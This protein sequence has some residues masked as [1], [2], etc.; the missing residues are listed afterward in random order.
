ML[1]LRSIVLDVKGL[2]AWLV[3]RI[4]LCK[5]GS[6]HSTEP[7]GNTTPPLIHSP[8]CAEKFIESDDELTTCRCAGSAQKK[9]SR[10]AKMTDRVGGAMRPF[11]SR[12]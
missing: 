5:L 11:Y 2:V 6:D 8:T 10:W 4:S 7:P 12:N 1:R 3:N 9:A